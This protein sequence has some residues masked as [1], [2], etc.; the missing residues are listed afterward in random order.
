MDIRTGIPELTLKRDFFWRLGQ[1]RPVTIYR[2]VV[3]GAIEE[4]IYRQIFGTQI[5]D[6][7]S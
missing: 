3:S 4:K 6:G 2:L 5:S 1:T 7:R